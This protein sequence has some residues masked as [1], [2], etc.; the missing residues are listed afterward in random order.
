MKLNEVV[1]LYS[2]MRDLATKE[3]KAS[4]AFKFSRI[5]KSLENEIQNFEEQR[6]KLIDQY[7]EKDENGEVIS[8]EDGS[9][10]I[11]KDREEEMIKEYQD[12][13]NTELDL[14]F[15]KVTIDE[16][17]TIDGITPEKLIKLD[18]IIEE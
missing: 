10:K 3:M 11:Q 9:I 8:Q 13:M 4:L 18:S 16:L 14:T 12:L 1:E 6:Q 7:G 17:D 5:I 2:N 15:T